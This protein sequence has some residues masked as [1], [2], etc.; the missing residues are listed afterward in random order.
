MIFYISCCCC[1]SVAQSCLTLCDPMDISMPGLP[2]PHHLLEFAQVHVHCIGDVVHPSHPL[3]PFSSSAL[4]LSQ[5]QGFFQW[6]SCSHHMIKILV[7]QLQ[8]KSFQWI[9]RVDPPYDWLVWFLCSPRDFE[10]SFSAPQFE[11]INSLAFCLPFTWIY[12]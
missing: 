3:M 10:E 8:H 6:V 12:L 7:L 5:N 2:V 9:F 1:C 4:N 11:G